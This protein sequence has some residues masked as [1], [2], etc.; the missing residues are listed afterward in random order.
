[1]NITIAYLGEIRNSNITIAYL[2]EN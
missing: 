2:G 1:L